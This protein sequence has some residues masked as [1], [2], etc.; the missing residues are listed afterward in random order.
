MRYL[1][2]SSHIR[3]ALLVLVLYAGCNHTLREFSPA[4]RQ[5]KRAISFDDSVLRPTNAFRK[6]C[7]LAL[8]SLANFCPASV[9]ENCRSSLITL[10]YLL[11]LH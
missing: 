1:P 11:G 10:R 3:V 4:V 6:D 8:L 7:G 9:H 2:R 5:Q